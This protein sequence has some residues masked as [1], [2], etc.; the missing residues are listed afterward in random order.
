MADVLAGQARAADAIYDDTILP[1]NLGLA[2]SELVLGGK[3]G[4]EM[5]LRRA[6]KDVKRGY[7]VVLVD[8][9]PSLGLLT[10]NA[11]VAADQALLSTEAQYFSLQGVE[12]ALEVIELAKENLHP[13]LEWLGV[14]LNIA[15]LRTIH[16]REALQ[17]L[18]DRFGDKVFDT[19]IRASIRYAESAERGVS[20]LDYR[21]E[22]GADYLALADE[23]LERLGFNEERQRV[24]AL[25]RE[26][27]PA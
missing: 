3:M 8:C 20:I 2:E 7:D 27:I 25:T 5:T 6:L 14:V 22:L 11:V 13:D 9:P 23:V 10:V 12:Q 17:S 24:A 1:A 26:L 4:R 15:D 18:R 19:V 21:P 16:S